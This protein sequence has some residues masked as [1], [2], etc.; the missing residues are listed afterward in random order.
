VA[1]GFVGTILSLFSLVGGILSIKRKFWGI[2][3]FGAILGLFTISGTLFSVISL[4]LL[5]VS[6]KE[7]V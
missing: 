5:F 7:F 2:A 4:I 6:K 1:I 3:L